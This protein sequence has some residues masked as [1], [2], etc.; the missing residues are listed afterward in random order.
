MEQ[1]EWD[2]CQY[3]QKGLGI[4]M[5]TGFCLV[6]HIPGAPYILC[7]SPKFPSYL[8]NSL[9]FLPPQFAHLECGSRLQRRLSA[10]P[11]AL[12]V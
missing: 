3:P 5:A 8:G 11:A 12:A 1:E 6:A 2:A 9:P 7:D 4:P 10:P